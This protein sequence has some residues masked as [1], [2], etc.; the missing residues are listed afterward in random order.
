MVRV[1]E[2][3]QGD[4]DN[5]QRGGKGVVLRENCMLP[6]LVQNYSLQSY[7]PRSTVQRSSSAEFA[8]PSFVIDCPRTDSFCLRLAHS[9]DAADGYHSISV[10]SSFSFP[11]D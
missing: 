2:N 3:L 10:T 7:V 8:L 1:R 5:R 4:V 9:D 6:S 11:L